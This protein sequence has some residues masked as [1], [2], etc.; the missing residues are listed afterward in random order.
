[1]TICNVCCIMQSSMRMEVGVKA[2]E[3]ETTEKVTRLNVKQEAFA[4]ALAR[5]ASPD[6]AMAKA[7]YL[8]DHDSAVK[9]SRQP[10]IVARVKALVDAAQWSGS[11]DLAPVIDA[12]RQLFEES[13]DLKSA[14]AIKERREILVQ[15]ARLKALLPRPMSIQV[16]AP[17][18]TDEEWEEKHVPKTVLSDLDRECS[19]REIW[20]A[21]ADR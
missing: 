20:L 6:E 17:D 13:R 19:R 4:K 14:A 16:R 9:R 7:G 15:V 11:A 5:G 10:V 21:S 8:P 18:L 12:M 1:M 3:V 2:A